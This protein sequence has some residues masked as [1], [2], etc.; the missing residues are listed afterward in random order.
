MKFLYS[1]SFLLGA[2]NWKIEPTPKEVTGSLESF[3]KDN[4]TILDLGCGDGSHCLTLAKD[5]W[6]VIGVDYV[7]LAIHRA[8]RAA[9]KAGLAKQADFMVGDVC[10]L[11]VLNLPAIDFAYDIGCF[12]LLAPR[13][14]EKYIRGLAGVIKPKGLF[15]LKAFTPRLQGKKMV[16]YEA[17]EIEQQFKPFFTIEKTSEHSYWRFPA[18]WYW[19]R[20]R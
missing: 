18:R 9:N 16:G 20:R 7:P 1:L 19:M 13:Q 11:G 15:L 8:R 12:H 6:K 2:D 3:A 17:T 10:Q 14:A 4:T 5:G